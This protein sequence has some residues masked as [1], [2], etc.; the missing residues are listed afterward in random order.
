MNLHEQPLEEN[1]FFRLAQ[2]PGTRLVIPETFVWHL[3]PKRLRKSIQEHGL[4][5]ELSKHACIF[6]NNQ[7]QD[8]CLFFPFC[9]D[10]YMDEIGK[11]GHFGDFDYWRI[12]TRLVEADWYLDI[13]MATGEKV[14]SPEDWAYYAGKVENFIA[15]EQSI[16]PAALRLFVLDPEESP[17]PLASFEAVGWA[18]QSSIYP[19]RSQIFDV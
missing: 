5:P 10:F 16:P 6:V 9:I 17:L 1:Q 8:I 15:T 18:D 11:N 7:S 12:D 13:N 2:A 3:A 14:L 4:L 19:W